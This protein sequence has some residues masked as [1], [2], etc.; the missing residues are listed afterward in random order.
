MQQ[1]VDHGRL[2]LARYQY[3]SERLGVLD[4]CQAAFAWEKL[5]LEAG[6]PK[7]QSCGT[8]EMRPRG[9]LKLRDRPNPIVGADELLSGEV[10]KTA[11]PIEAPICDGD[12]QVVDQE[13]VVRVIEIDDTGQFI[14]DEQGIVAKQIGMYNATRKST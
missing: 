6:Q 11:A 14:A 8:D 5:A 12:G 10:V 7:P 2:I 1:G 9:P 4:M 3:L 13:T